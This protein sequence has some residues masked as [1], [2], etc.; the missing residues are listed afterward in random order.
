MKFKVIFCLFAIYFA[1]TLGAPS[2]DSTTEKSPIICDIKCADGYAL[3]ISTGKCLCVPVEGCRVQI[4]FNPDYI[5]DMETCSCILD[6]NLSVPSVP[7]E[8]SSACWMAESSC[9]EHSYFD[10]AR[11]ECI[12]LLCA[13]D[14]PPGYI[15][16]GCACVPPPSS[17]PSIDICD[18]NLIKCPD[19][20][21]LDEILCECVE[22]LDPSCPD[23]R[24]WDAASC[25]CICSNY[26]DC[27]LNFVWDENFCDCIC[28]KGEYCFPGMYF[29]EKTCSCKCD[30]YKECETG[31]FFNQ[32]TCR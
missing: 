28:P 16:Y 12:P 5:W 8:S 25:S 9:P 31:F 22:N 7:I 20:L 29:D 3:D 10:N 14:C 24:Y 15:N 26:T 1:A 23:G 21:I 17:E 30:H 4:C 2:E 13:I 27:R 11:C 18:P 19:G 32:D 6:P